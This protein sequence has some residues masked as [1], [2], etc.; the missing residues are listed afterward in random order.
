[1]EE[2]DE[3]LLQR[4]AVQNAKYLDYLDHM[5]LEDTYANRK[6]MNLLDN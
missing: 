4:E 6:S 3:K 1:M 5:G 2:I